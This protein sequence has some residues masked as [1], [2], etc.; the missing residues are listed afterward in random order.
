MSFSWAETITAGS[1]TIKSLHFTEL[2]TNI[3]IE[4]TARGLGVYSWGQ[5]PSQYTNKHLNAD[6]TDMRTALDQAHTENYCHTV[7]THY[8]THNPSYNATV[9]V[10]PNN[11]YVYHA[12]YGPG[13]NLCT[14]CATYYSTY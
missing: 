11:Y 5:T 7:G 13:Y 6:M 8:A 3:G 14:Q 2:H 12:T 10:C 9:Y 1:T 4:R